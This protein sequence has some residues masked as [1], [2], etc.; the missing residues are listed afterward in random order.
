MF[1]QK[2]DLSRRPYHR[3]P[4]YGMSFTAACLGFRTS[5]AHHGRPVPHLPVAQLLLDSRCTVGTVV[6]HTTLVLR[7]II[8]RT[9]TARVR[10]YK[11]PRPHT[12]TVLCVH[13]I[14]S[15]VSAFMSNSI[16]RGHSC[17]L[18]IVMC[19]WLIECRMTATRG[20]CGNTMCIF[21][22]TLGSQCQ[23]L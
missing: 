14:L 4:A 20:C 11:I 1:T 15:T 10:I 13:G 12:Q 3:M 7:Y 23:L 17:S 21:T 16:I 2:R 9:K 22:K 8:M 6:L 19:S 18:H 5:I